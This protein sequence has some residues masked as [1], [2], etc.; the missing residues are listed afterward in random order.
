MSYYGRC[1]S[2]APEGRHT[3]I[4][5]WTNPLKTFSGSPI[6]AFTKIEILRDGTLVGELDNAEPGKESTYTDVVAPD[7]GAT[8]TYTVVPYTLGGAG[9]PAEA[10]AF[11]GT[12]VPAKVEDITIT[13]IT[14][15]SAK[16]S[17]KAVTTGANGGWISAPTYKVVRMPEGETMEGRAAEC[18]QRICPAENGCVSAFRSGCHGKIFNLTRCAVGNHYVRHI[19][20]GQLC[21]ADGHS[22]GGQTCGRIDGGDEGFLNFYCAGLIEGA[23]G[24]CP[25]EHAAFVVEFH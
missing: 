22:A 12:D 9:I 3:A 14:P 5:R 4:L 17:W 21:L 1:S 25:V 7:G 20:S 8:H 16:V 6:K 24:S 13:R 2:S 19:Q 15:N 10:T 18:F 23:H 11:I